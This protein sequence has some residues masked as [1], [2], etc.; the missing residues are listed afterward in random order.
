MQK[1][2]CYCEDFSIHLKTD[3]SGRRE[4]WFSGVDVVPAQKF[5]FRGFALP[6]FGAKSGGSFFVTDDSQPDPCSRN[7][8]SHYHTDSGRER[9]CAWY[10]PRSSVP[11]TLA[12]LRPIFEQLGA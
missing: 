3:G 9:L 7:C 10:L 1:K 6:C 4:M 11:E 2:C 8:L 5:V 12:T